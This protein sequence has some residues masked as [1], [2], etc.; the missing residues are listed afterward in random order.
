MSVHTDVTREK[1]LQRALR[2]A[3]ERYDA[4]VENVPCGVQ[5]V[6][7]RPNGTYH[8]DFV[9]PRTAQL[10]GVPLEELQRDATLWMRNAWPEDAA[11]AA[12]ENARCIATKE[13]YTWE[14]RFTVAGTVRW[15]RFEGRPTGQNDGDFLW[16]AVVHDITEQKGL[17]AAQREAQKLAALGHFAGGM[18]H[19]FNNILASMLMTIGL[20]QHDE[21]PAS[22][23]ESLGDL[24]KSCVR[25][26]GLIKQLLAFSQKSVLRPQQFVLNDFLASRLPSLQANLGPGCRVELTDCPQALSVSGD[27]ALLEQAVRNLC[28]NACDAMRDG[29]LARIGLEAVEVDAERCQRNAEARPGRFACLSVSDQGCGMDAKTRLRLFEPFF[30][31]K[32]V[33]RGTGLGLATVRGIIRQHQGWVEVESEV[34]RGSCFRLHL[35][36]ARAVDQTS[37]PRPASPAPTGA[38]ATI[39]LAEDDPGLRTIVS[40]IL[41]RSGYRVFEAQ[42]AAAAQKLWEAHGDE[43]DLLLSDVVMPGA[44][45]GYELAQRLIHQR[46]GLKVILTSGYNTTLED[47]PAEL[48]DRMVYLAKPVPSELLLQTIKRSLQPAP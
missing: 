1:Q 34:G 28:E 36:L 48:R 5:V 15:L 7:L 43:I 16:N 10:I 42:D 35:P 3:K 33:G 11:K 37:V 12:Q 23:V 6:R 22:I 2:E 21:A 18:A 44:E 32:E 9:S 39:L 40:R 45:S 47:Q 46:P 31:T 20:A 17:E 41:K 30:T 13:P 14:G 27:P 8:F 19:E 29:G 4:L 25:A 38:I 24:E 26:G